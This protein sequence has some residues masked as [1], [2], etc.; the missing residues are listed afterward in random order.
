MILFLST[1][2]AIRWLTT[3][4]LL[5][6]PSHFS[7]DSHNATVDLFEII[8]HLVEVALDPWPVITQKAVNEI[9][10]PMGFRVQRVQGEWWIS[11]EPRHRYESRNMAMKV[12]LLGLQQY[13][14]SDLPDGEQ[15]SQ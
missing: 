6:L 12:A 2:N 14:S 5:F 15:L 4:I 13:Y 8:T 3:L 10:K 11:D 7:L 1:L 9:R